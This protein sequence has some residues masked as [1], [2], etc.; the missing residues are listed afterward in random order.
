MPSLS[1]RTRAIGRTV[2][3][4][5]AVA[6]VVALAA[7]EAAAQLAPVPVVPP[8]VLDTIVEDFRAAVVAARP[9]LLGIAASTFGVL[10]VIEIALSAIVWTLRESGPDRILSALVLKLAWLAFAF[11]LIA[12]FSVWFP[13][14]IDGFQQAG[15]AVAPGVVSPGDVL[16]LG[17]QL[18]TSMVNSFFD[19]VGLMDLSFSLV[20]TAI[21][22]ALAAFFVELMYAVIAAAVV[23]V[24]VESFIA[25]A[26]GALVL[27]FAAFRG[28]ANLADRFVAY[29]FNLGIRLFSLFLL[30]GIGFNVAQTWLPVIQSSP[31]DVAAM[32]AVL[33]GSLTFM[34][35]VVVIPHKVSTLLTRD[36]TVGFERAL[37]AV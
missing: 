19:G 14:I 2:S 1:P 6:A 27:G 20:A 36:L 5:A 15:Q 33:G 31:D 23:V 3:R 37:S 11:G 28:T 18:S 35:L 25:L 7:P 24:I 17:V 30:V 9:A 16:G 34:L 32:L 13:P 4:C 26:A 29:V 8:P 21:L 10:A 12:S 22:V